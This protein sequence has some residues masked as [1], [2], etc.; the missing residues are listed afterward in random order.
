ME[1]KPLLIYDGDCNFCINWVKKLKQ[2]VGNQI[3]Y[4]SLQKAAGRFPEI[5]R[6]DFQKAVQLILP[7][8]ERFSG[9]RA[10]LKVLSYAPKRKWLLWLYDHIPGFASFSEWAYRLAA[11]RRYCSHKKLG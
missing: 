9:A 5:P 6:Q 4:E 8:G 10:V 11:R 1:K 7:S 2:K 3:D